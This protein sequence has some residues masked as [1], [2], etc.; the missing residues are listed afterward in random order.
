MSEAELS[1]CVVQTARLFGW[2]V[3]LVRPART[4]HGWRTPF[5]ADGVGWPDITAVRNNQL[6]FGEL[7]ATKGKLTPEQTVWLEVLA[8]VGTTAVWR[9]SDWADGTVEEALR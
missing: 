2:R 9:P 1:D 7:K 3:L 4:Q 6:I 8:N 5:G